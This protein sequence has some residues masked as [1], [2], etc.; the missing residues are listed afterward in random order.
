PLADELLLL[1][2][3]GELRHSSR[4]ALLEQPE[5]WVEAGLR[6]PPA[7]E[8]AREAWRLGLAERQCGRP[9]DVAAFNRGRGPDSAG[10]AAAINRGGG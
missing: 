6:L 8:A 5:R 2:E 4:P 9:A 3:D 10:D 7:Y 1:G